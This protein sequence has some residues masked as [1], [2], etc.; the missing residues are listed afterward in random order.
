MLGMNLGMG[1]RIRRIRRRN[2]RMWI[3]MDLR[4]SKPR[5]EVSFSKSSWI[6]KDEKGDPRGQD[7]QEMMLRREYGTCG[8]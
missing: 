6:L 5:W 1:M 2:L 3:R 7:G 8:T 4:L